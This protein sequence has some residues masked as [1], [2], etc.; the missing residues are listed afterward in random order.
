MSS[1][2][3]GTSPRS[4]PLVFCVGLQKYLCLLTPGTSFLVSAPTTPENEEHGVGVVVHHSHSFGQ[5]VLPDE[6]APM[7]ATRILVMSSAGRLR[8]PTSSSRET[9]T[10]SFWR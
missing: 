7:R 2:V 3:P 6:R 8:M 9:W 1:S 10:R 4:W 5:E